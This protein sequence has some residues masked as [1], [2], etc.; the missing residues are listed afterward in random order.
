VRFLRTQTRNCRIW[1]DWKYRGL[2]PLIVPVLSRPE[3]AL[4]WLLPQLLRY[5]FCGICGNE[6]EGLALVARGQNSLFL[7][8]ATFHN[9]FCCHIYWC[10]DTQK[11]HLGCCSSLY[12]SPCLLQSGLYSEMCS[13]THKM[14][15]SHSSPA[16]GN[17]PG[18]LLCST[19]GSIR[20]KD[21]S[22]KGLDGKERKIILGCHQVYP[23][24]SPPHL[25]DRTG[26]D[27]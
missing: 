11:G 12:D 20:E 19:P 6:L 26:K 16:L 8:W 22:N 24:A 5:S 2:P 21:K 1:S 13:G 9:L 14:D 15:A 27:E 25:G 3:K 17:I 4:Q 10:G 23:G 7:R 18:K